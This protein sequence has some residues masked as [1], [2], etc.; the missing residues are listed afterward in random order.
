MKILKYKNKIIKDIHN[1]HVTKIKEY[2]TKQEQIA[3]KK[4]NKELIAEQNAQTTASSIIT[5]EQETSD[6][7]VNNNFPD[8]TLINADDY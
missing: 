2:T 6:S 3:L 8:N 5:T 4:K 1:M 7:P